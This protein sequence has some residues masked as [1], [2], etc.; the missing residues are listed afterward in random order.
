M[1]RELSALGIAIE[2]A[3]SARFRSHGD[4]VKYLSCFR[5]PGGRVF[6]CE[7]GTKKHVN[8]WVLNDAGARRAAE[9]AGLSVRLTAPWPTGRGGAYG[10]LSALRS[11]S[12]LSDEPLL[13]IQATTVGQ[14]LAVVEALS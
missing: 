10:R 5:T 14:A 7:R 8:I 3:L 1:A 13:M 11:V 9:D 6:G 4:P 2:D 12:E